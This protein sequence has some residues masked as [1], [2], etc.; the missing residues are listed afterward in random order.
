MSTRSIGVRLGSL[1]IFGAVSVLLS[2]AGPGQPASAEAADR[3]PAGRQCGGFLGLQ[4]N[5]DEW[6]EYDNP[7]SCGNAD[8][9][10]ACRPRPQVCTKDCPGVTGCDGE[11]YC[12]ACMAHRAGYDVQGSAIARE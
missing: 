5:P 4:C 7:G 10:G 12:N 2:G 3:P 11:F 8:Q 6:C 1:V 9:G